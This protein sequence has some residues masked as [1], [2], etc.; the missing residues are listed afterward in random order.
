MKTLRQLFAVIVLTLTIAVSSFAGDMHTTAPSP[1]PEPTPA[2]AEGD[3]TT[4]PGDMH[5]GYSDGATA[6]DAV[7]AGALSVLQD[8]VSLL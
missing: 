5:T 1:Q 2:T 3:T 8:L 6:G 4:A 7:A